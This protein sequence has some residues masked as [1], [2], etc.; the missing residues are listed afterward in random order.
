[1]H[2]KKIEAEKVETVKQKGWSRCSHWAIDCR[3]K[4]PRLWLHM[5][6]TSPHRQVTWLPV[7]FNTQIRWEMVFL[8]TACLR[9]AKPQLNLNWEVTFGPRDVPLSRGTDLLPHIC[10]SHV[11]S[12]IIHKQCSSYIELL[13][14]WTC[15]GVNAKAKHVSW[16]LWLL[17]DAAER[18]TGRREIFSNCECPNHIKREWS[19]VNHRFNVQGDIKT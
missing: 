12:S 13:I 9:Q 8:R 5:W 19:K 4:K 15:C 1:M 11:H 16:N 3:T 14:C 17:S 2:I 6:L 18:H 10:R 7:D